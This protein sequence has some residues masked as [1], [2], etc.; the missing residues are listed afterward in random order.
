[1]RVCVCGLCQVGSLLSQ[2]LCQHVSQVSLAIPELPTS[3]A[4]AKEPYR[5]HNTSTHSIPSF[6]SHP[7]LQHCG[8]G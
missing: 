1:M 8:E 2:M 4:V 6:Q 7:V 5:G 3:M